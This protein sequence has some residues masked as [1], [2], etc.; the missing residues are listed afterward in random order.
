MRRPRRGGPRPGSVTT[1]RVPSPRAA[2]SA[3]NE[4]GGSTSSRRIRR[5]SGEGSDVRPATVSVPQ[6]TGTATRGRISATAS[7]AVDRVEVARAEVGAPA[8]DGQQG[9]VDVPLGQHAHAV[10]QP[11]VAAGVDGGAAAL[12]QEAQRLRGRPVG[13][14]RAPAVPAVLGADGG[15]PQPAVGDRLAGGQLVDPR[16]AAAAQPCTGA[17]GHDDPRAGR[18]CAA[19]AGAG[20]RRAG[21]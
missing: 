9:D 10:E 16:E 13:R 7:A 5:R 3:A 15:D 11:G 20:G 12:E 14:A 6:C 1:T 8:P 2:T 18:R 4:R 21:G 19:T 17:A